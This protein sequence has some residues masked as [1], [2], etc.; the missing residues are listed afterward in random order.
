MAKRATFAGIYIRNR[1]CEAASA[2][3]CAERE[4]DGVVSRQEQRRGSRGSACVLPAG[5]GHPRRPT[6]VIAGPLRRACPIVLLALLALLAAACERAPVELSPRQRAELDRQMQRFAAA[7]MFAIAEA[8]EVYAAE[9]IARFPASPEAA[10]LR[11]QWASLQ[12]E[13]DERRAERR[14]AELWR[15]NA[16]ENPRG[17]ELLAELSSA[18]RDDAPTM[19]LV[20]R[21]HPRFGQSVYL[22]IEREA[23]FACERSCALQMRFDR[24]SA[25]VF[26]ARRALDN[27][28]P[29]LFL[30]DDQAFIAA[31]EA[32]DEMRIDV[33]LASGERVSYR[34]EVGGYQ[35]ERM[36]EDG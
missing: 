7:R 36:R 24:S 28:P 32:A 21:R 27:V 10:A 26:A 8:A 34:F 12:A 3:A 19:R 11:A 15:Y 23:D 13:A 18:P 6:A 31:L 33:V 35:P 9:I 20:L 16:A 17:L 14:R 22:L 5:G 2:A 25:Q 30:R 4:M 29:A 1:K